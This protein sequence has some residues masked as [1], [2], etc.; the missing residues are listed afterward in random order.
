MGWKDAK[1][2]RRV[3]EQQRCGLTQPPL[4]SSHRI[5]S[6]RVRAAMLG[7]DRY[8]TS[9]HT[10]TRSAGRQTVQTGTSA[11]GQTA[12]TGTVHCTQYEGVVCAECA[13]CAE[14][15]T[16]FRPP[17]STP[18]AARRR[19]PGDVAMHSMFRPKPIGNWHLLKIARTWPGE[20]RET[21]R[22]RG[23]HGSKHSSPSSS[24]VLTVNRRPCV[25]LMSTV[26]V[27]QLPHCFFNA[28]PAVLLP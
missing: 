9:R 8:S 24:A 10:G 21:P 14:S 20:L 27:L 26:S 23:Y 15:P 1:N 6:H 28:A 13:E 7:T 17:S 19:Q 4:M 18:V 11:S 5:A 3:S 22:P 2:V 12:Q 25:K 16:L